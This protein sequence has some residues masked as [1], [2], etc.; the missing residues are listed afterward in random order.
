MSESNASSIS[1][2]E[3]I[4]NWFRKGAALGDVESMA[5]LGAANMMGIGMQ[6][7]YTEAVKWLRPAAEKGDLT[8][9]NNLGVCY[10]N[11]YGVEKDY[12]IA[13]RLIRNAAEKGDAK[14]QY[15]LGNLY[16]LGYSVQQNAKIAF[17]WWLKAAKGGDINAQNNVGFLYEA[18]EVVAQDLVEAYKWMALA[19]EQGYTGAA[20]HRDQIASK[21][22]PFELAESNN[23]IHTQ[24]YQWMIEK[25]NRV[26]GLGIIQRLAQMGDSEARAVLLGSSVGATGEIVYERQ[27][28]SSDVRREVW[29]RDQGRCARCGSREKLEYDHIIPV[30]K[31][32]SNTARNIELLCEA[33]NRSKSDSIQ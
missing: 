7:N 27:A 14:G 18:G 31:G 11:G 3:S 5:H 29:R 15:H 4:M 22:T 9:Q 12:L 16:H 24:K 6:T 17:D 32:G 28:L 19:A 20:E 23:R 26:E 30:S 1:S 33:C 8:A 25:Q 10:L 21:M 2:D 13:E